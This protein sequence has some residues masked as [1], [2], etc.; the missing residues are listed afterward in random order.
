[1]ANRE[2]NRCVVDRLEPRRLMAATPAL[3]AAGG[4]AYLTEF[5]PGTGAVVA[6]VTTPAGT[7][8]GGV[9]AVAADPGGDAFVIDTASSDVLRVAAGTAAATVFVA[10][11]TGGL[12]AP[13]GLAVAGDGTVVIADK[14]AVFAFTPGGKLAGKRA[15]AGAVAVNAGPDGLIYVTAVSVSSS[16]FTGYATQRYTP[17]GLIPVG[18]AF[19][20]GTDYRTSGGSIGASIGGDGLLYAVDDVYFGDYVGP[21]DRN[22]TASTYAATTGTFVAAVALDGLGGS[23]NK[24]AVDAAG[25]L[26]ANA[27]D[28]GIDVRSAATGA[29]VRE[30]VPGHGA[31]LP[32]GT[33]FYV[34]VTVPALPSGA[35]F[36]SRATGRIRTSAGRVTARLQ[37]PG[38]GRLLV[39]PA[40]AN[41]FLVELSGT[42]ARSALTITEAGGTSPLDQLQADAAVGAVVAA[43]VPV[44]GAMS[45][46]GTV[47]RLAVGDLAGDVT[48]GK[49]TAAARVTAGAVAAGSSLTTAAPVA[50]IAFTSWAAGTDANPSRISAPSI[51]TLDCRGAF[52]ADLGL[53][54]SRSD[55]KRATFGSLAGATI[56]AVGG[57]GTIRVDG[58]VADT[59]VNA[60]PGGTVPGDP[61]ATFGTP[62]E[63]LAAFVQPA[64]ATFADSR[65]AAYSIGRVST[66]TAVSADGD[67]FGVAG[68]V[69][70]TVTMPPLNGGRPLRHPTAA[71]GT[72]VAAV[73]GQ[74]VVQV[75]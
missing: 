65:V 32:Y 45:F 60:A 73:D 42:T 18:T 61:I 8:T 6:T 22:A 67:A 44:D 26:Y 71:A 14:A 17:A 9:T 51:G 34:P 72:I 15:A 46:A 40:A 27:P 4:G 41:G 12:G 5:D 31:T 20:S 38:T 74:V 68:H 49:G 3:Y 59:L 21:N 11:G 57:I 55:L 54:G 24:V 69:I 28:G 52:S 36:T 1:M 13:V 53:T 39:D 10:A 35:T 47:G 16:G 50:S 48:V 29:V 30:L 37:G 70:G 56:T 64:S 7:G 19:S 63:S 75:F 62:A 23:D 66:G 2:P 33:L 58:D 25:D 43:G